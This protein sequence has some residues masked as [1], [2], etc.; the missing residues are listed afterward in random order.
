[1]GCRMSKEFSVEI[2]DSLLERLD[3]HELDSKEIINKALNQFFESEKQDNEI[4]TTL[5]QN[6]Q[7][8]E[9]Q[10][11]LMEIDFAC[12]MGENKK[13]QT[14]IDDLARLY[15]TAVTL[16]GKTPKLGKLGRKK[17]GFQ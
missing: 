12:L 11:E 4:V 5:K 3:S 8:L 9:N 15:P 14:R 7:E 16:L 2:N 17:A 1:M 6:V 10:K 13:L